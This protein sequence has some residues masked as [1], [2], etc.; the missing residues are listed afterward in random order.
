LR[1]EGRVSAPEP[2][3]VAVQG[4]NRIVGVALGEVKLAALERVG[5][6]G[7]QEHG[8]PLAGADAGELRE[9]LGAALAHRPAELPL[10]VGEVQKWRGRGELLTL[11]EHRCAR[12]EEQE[13]RHGAEAAG[14]G[15]PMQA[16]AAD[17]VRDLIVVLDEGDEGRGRQIE[18]GR[19]APLPLPLVPLPLVKV[20]ILDGGDELLG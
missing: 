5:V 11:E 1:A 4:V 10:V 16:L 2:D 20:A 6:G 19:A 8:H 17:R 18:G 9:E 7:V 3:Q 12:R 14:T 13:R 15:R